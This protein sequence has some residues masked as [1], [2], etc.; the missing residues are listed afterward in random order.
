MSMMM[1][2]SGE[3]LIKTRK[4]DRLEKKVGDDAVCGQT[5]SNVSGSWSKV[6]M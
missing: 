1:M 6:F 5:Y 4:P 2:P 3:R